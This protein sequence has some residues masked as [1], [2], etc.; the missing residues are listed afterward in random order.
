MKP[1]LLFMLVVA[2]VSCIACKKSKKA[3]LVT[4]DTLLG[5][6]Q[7]ASVGIIFRADSTY[8][9]NHGGFVG[10]KYGK[11]STRITDSSAHILQTI[12]TW[13][14]YGTRDTFLIR[15]ASSNR[16]VITHG[17]STMEYTRYQ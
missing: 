13:N 8:T 5:V 10:S 7:Q 17:P 3:D 4:P 16:L 15:I 11:F 9:E 6:W 12:V 14:G 2:G 1:L